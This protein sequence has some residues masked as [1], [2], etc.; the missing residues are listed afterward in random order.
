[1]IAHHASVLHVKD[2]QLNLE[3]FS[4]LGFQKT[5][6]WGKTIEYLIMKAGDTSIHISLADKPHQ[7][8]GQTDVYI[9]V[10][11]IEEYHENIVNK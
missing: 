9:F 10:S 5:F 6:E 11:N 3:F 2:I 7:D 1:M 4:K 8:S